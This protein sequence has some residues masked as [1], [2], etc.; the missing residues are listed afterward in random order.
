[1]PP[2]LGGHGGARSGMAGSKNRP[3]RRARRH[4]SPTGPYRL[5]RADFAGQRTRHGIT[6]PHGAIAPRIALTFRATMLS[7]PR[8][9]LANR[10][11][12]T[13]RRGRGAG[14]DLSGRIARMA[15][16]RCGCQQARGQLPPGRRFRSADFQPFPAIFNK[17]RPNG[18]NGKPHTT[19]MTGLGKPRGRPRWARLGRPEG[20]PGELLLPMRLT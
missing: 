1:M 8:A 7:T 14:A 16:G 6:L 18:L 5:P 4:G 3:R 10:R 9:N 15:S 11:E 19:G 2:G 13:W 20:P 17:K 12:R